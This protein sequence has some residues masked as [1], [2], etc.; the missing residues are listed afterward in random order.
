MGFLVVDV[1]FWCVLVLLQLGFPEF[2][3]TLQLTQAVFFY[4]FELKREKWME[5]IGR[6]ALRVK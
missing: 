5:W 2:S 4:F 6:Y 3:L 1:K